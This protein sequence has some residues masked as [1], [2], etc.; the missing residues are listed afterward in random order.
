MRVSYCDGYSVRL[1][2]G[3]PFP[4]SKFTALHGILLGKGVIQQD[5]VR[6]PQ[7]AEWE[8][9]ARVHTWDYLDKLRMGKLDQR[10]LR[11][12][13]LPW[14]EA[15]VRRSRFAVQGTIN[16]ALFAL[17]D[18]IGANLA[19]GTHHSF[20]DRGEGFCVLN[21]VA[22]TIRSLCARSLFQR[23]LVIDLDVHQG[24]GTAEIFAQ[25]PQVYT[26]SMHGAKNYPFHKSTSSF[27]LG[28]PDGADDAH[29][30]QRLTEALPQAF[31]ASRPQIVFYLAGVDPRRGDRFGRLCLTR[32]GLH[33][34][35][36]MVL[37]ATWKRGV[38]IVLL[39]SG[40][41]AR[42]PQETADLHA[43]T[44]REARFVYG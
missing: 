35:D 37:E 43:I 24:N 15:L 26:F 27:D 12:L 21:D 39:L 34:R 30:V 6:P 10:E 38:P 44:H 1:P 9:L 29:Y 16:A 32:Q 14:S 41:Y 23:V 4:I 22:V 8:D 33:E 3:H 11:R 20:A 36:R 7:Q 40:G 25:D 18:G 42:T 28:L 2:Q 31:D 17:Q 5:D 19:G 13:G